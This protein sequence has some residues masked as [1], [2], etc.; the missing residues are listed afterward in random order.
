MYNKVDAELF[1]QA[2]KWLCNNGKI[3]QTNQV[4][5]QHKVAIIVK[6]EKIGDIWRQNFVCLDEVLAWWFKGCDDWN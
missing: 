5:K 6:L 2:W 1:G 4:E 3:T